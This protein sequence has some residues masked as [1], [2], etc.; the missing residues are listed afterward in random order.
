MSRIEDLNRKDIKIPKEPSILWQKWDDLYKVAV[1]SA[2]AEEDKAQLENPE[3]YEDEEDIEAFEEE[4]ELYQRPIQTILTPL[5]ILPVN[6]SVLATTHFKFWMGHT[7]F[8]ITNKHLLQ[9]SKINGVESLSL[10]S[11]HRFLISIGWLFSDRD[12]MKEI[13]EKIAIDPTNKSK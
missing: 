2:Q 10:H 4:E 9:I 8:R 7:N 5:G 3:S 11:P 13:K 1:E 6:D 12:V